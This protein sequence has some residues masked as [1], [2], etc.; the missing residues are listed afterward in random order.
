MDPEAY[1]SAMDLPGF[2]LLI[3]APR[4][5]GAS[6]RPSS[7]DGYK[8]DG[9]VADVESLRVHLGVETL[10]LYGNSHGGC[11]ALAY[12]C[13]SP[14]RVDRFLVTNAP[15][16][17]DD[18]YNKAA[19]E[20][21]RRFSEAF[22]DG[23]ERL[24]AAEK[25]YELMNATDVGSDEWK[26]HYR[27]LMAR[28]VAH[29]GVA[30]AAYLDRLC[31]APVN[32]ESVEVMYGEFTDGLDLLTDTAKVT[33]PALVIAGEFDVVVPPIAMRWI[34]DALPNGRYF[35]FEGIGHFPEVEA[36]PQFSEL[37]TNFL[38]G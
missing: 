2:E 4:G 27:T 8:I 3:F 25:A 19:A 7:V 32:F 35:E 6:S 34:A 38:A 29:Q 30:E 9:F 1:F 23:A 5:T 28:Y 24:E 12:A 16:R 26:R 14:E 37:V 15:P 18:A 21:Q 17:M 22:P 13:R 33:A 11:V 10:T 20:V 31:S 36:G